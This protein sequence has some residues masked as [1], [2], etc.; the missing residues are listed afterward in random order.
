MPGKYSFSLGLFDGIDSAI[1]AI[2]SAG[3]VINLNRFAASFLNLARGDEFSQAVHPDS[4]Q[5]LTIALQQPGKL[6]QIQFKLQ[7][8][9]SYGQ[10]KCLPEDQNQ[11]F[12]ENAENNQP[13]ILLI[14]DI[15][16]QVA[17]ASQLHQGV[18]PNRKFIHDISNAL[19]T[20]LGYTELIAMML[21]E[22][23]VL[24]GERLVAIQR[25][26]GEVYSGLQRA[27]KL[28]KDQKASRMA[29]ADDIKSDARAPKRIM[30]VDDEASITEFLTELL[31]GHNYLV[32]AFTSAIEALEHYKNHQSKID[33]VIVDHLMPELSGIALATALLAVNKELPIV[34]CG[35]E[36]ST[37]PGTGSQIIS[38]PLNG[39]GEI[40]YFINKPLDI[41]EL[42]KLVRSIVDSG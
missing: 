16:E 33:L 36:S 27:T 19:T 37:E 6:H 20:T 35:L 2:D 32:S 4:Q 17:L 28:I 18:Q 39:A 13:R 31:Q 22:G 41:N 5:Q 7:Q 24:A 15:S 11:A 3:I 23:D 8:G 25:Y 38:P 30:V 10:L 34:L 26:Q 40:K 21:E 12:P 29:A 9:S 42:V 1:I 14:Q